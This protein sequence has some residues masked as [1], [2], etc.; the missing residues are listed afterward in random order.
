M[1]TMTA[2]TQQTVL[3]IKDV[4]KVTTPEKT[5]EALKEHLKV[6]AS[7]QISVRSLRKAYGGTQIATVSLPCNLAAAL[8]QKGH[9]RIG[10]V[11]CRVRTKVEIKRC[12]KCWGLGH[13]AIK[14]QGPDRSRTCRRCGG[15]DHQAK[16]CENSPCCL[17][18]QDD[19]RKDS[20]HA[21][22]SYACPLVQE[23]IRRS[24]SKS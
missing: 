9:V 19:R 1:A 14:C 12:F 24:K 20:N 13:M 15:S 10:W 17:I 18:C 7:D 6:K 3:E 16:N 8:L 4:D 2:V 22:Y 11:N 21:S 5:M 23:F